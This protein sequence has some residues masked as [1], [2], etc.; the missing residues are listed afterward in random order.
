MYMSGLVDDLHT[1]R[2]VDSKELFTYYLLFAFAR[3]STVLN[4]ETHLYC[5]I[6]IS[7]AD[8]FYLDS[9]DR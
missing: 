8:M 4:T 5:F 2:Q 7:T 3:L 6:Y 1:H 9:H